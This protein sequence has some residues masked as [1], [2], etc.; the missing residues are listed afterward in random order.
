[1]KLG[2]LGSTGSVG[3]QTLEVY[4]RVGGDVELVG[5]LA[6]RA[7]EKLLSQA[8]RYKPRFV[9]SYEEPTKEWLSRLPSGT[10]FL[11]GD[12]GLD[13]IISESDRLMN[14]VSGV[15]G[16][17][18]A[19]EILRKGKV[20]LASNKESILCLGDFIREHRGRVLPVDSEHNALFQ[21]LGSVS[22]EEVKNVFIT[23]SGGPFRDKK[24][25]ELKDVSVEDA[26]KHP[27][28]NMG[29]KITVDSA[30][31]MNKGFE[32]LEASYLFDLPLDMIKVVIHPQSVV[33]AILELRDNSFLMHAS[34]TDMRIPIMHALFYPKRMDYPFGRVSPLELSGLVFERVDTKKFRALELARWA[35]YMGGPYVPVLVGA[36]EEAVELF[37][38][39]KIPFLRI[40][41]LIE[42][43]LEEVELQ[44][45]K[46]I[47]EIVEAVEWGRR[48]VREIYEREYA[49]KV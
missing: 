25:E 16:I 19:Y 49:G 28:W 31:L 8:I 3:S 21:L 30:T 14:A 13:A 7:S 46:T 40:V 42:R 34:P 18:P 22:R 35:G 32:V 5:I 23:A 9:V 24:I 45:P 26:L 15:H 43:A 48:K 20:L 47:E 10:K 11:K 39:G 6:R 12:E 2:V 29:A 1:M 33:H 36:D 37:L 27:R 44:E 41:E 38:K 17:K 4:E